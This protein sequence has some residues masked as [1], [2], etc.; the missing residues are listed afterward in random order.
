MGTDQNMIVRL[1]NIQA[2]CQKYLLI[3][4]SGEVVIISNSYEL[5]LQ[6]F[7]RRVKNLLD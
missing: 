1:S 7:D 2:C 4:G 3:Q 6:F 5:S